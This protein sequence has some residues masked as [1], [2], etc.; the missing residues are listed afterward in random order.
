MTR[1]V[2]GKANPTNPR[3]MCMVQNKK[4]PMMIKAGKI[5]NKGSKNKQ[6]RIPLTLTNTH[7]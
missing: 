1:I 3:A 7:L 2:I 4:I 6:I 5:N